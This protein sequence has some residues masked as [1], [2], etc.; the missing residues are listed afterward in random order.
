[1]GKLSFRS[2][3]R[4]IRATDAFLTKIVFKIKA[5]NL[6]QFEEIQRSKPDK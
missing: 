6:L 3:K 4:P 1:M 2:V 5:V